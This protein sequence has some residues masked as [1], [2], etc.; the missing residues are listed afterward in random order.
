MKIKKLLAYY[1]SSPD[2][3]A[4]FYENAP[5]S[6]FCPLCNSVLDRDYIPPKIKLYGGNLPDL[7]GTYDGQAM[8]SSRFKLFCEAEKLDVDFYEI[9]MGKSFYHF[10]PRN[11]LKYDAL[12]RKTRFINLCTSCGNFA[13]IIGSIP[14]FFAE[15]FEPVQVGIYRTDMEFG[16]G[17][18]KSFK[19][20][21]GLTT[22]E[23]M[24][25]QKFRGCTLLPIYL[26]E[27]LH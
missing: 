2:I 13:E 5:S 7:G 15:I 25:A 21:I 27:T 8:C 19:V 23:K 16:S 1:L 26:E 9:D 3:D 14:V 10:K 20:I 17:S 12:R 4:H 24:V 18:Q 11:A 22:R 6:T